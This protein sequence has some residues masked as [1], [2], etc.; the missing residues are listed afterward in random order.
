M[1]KK[2]W[3]AKGIQFECQGSGRCCVSR[4]GF[5]YVYLTLADRQRFARH[6][7]IPTA[8]FTREYCEKSDGYFHL[9]NAPDS[10]DCIFLKGGRCDAYL[11]RP[12][13]C[14]TWPF[15]PETLKAKAWDKDVAAY[16]PG[17]GKGKIHTEDEIRAQLNA[18]IKSEKHL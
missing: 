5:G 8:Q 16:C 9:K 4:N 17:V 12:T 15:W 18:Q 6:L 13:Q 2:E 7:K 14:R 3:W 11:A 1:A 10:E